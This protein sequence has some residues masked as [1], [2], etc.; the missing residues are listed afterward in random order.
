M[1]LRIVSYPSAE[2]I[3]LEEARLH[4]RV[5]ADG[6]PP[7]HPDDSLILGL[8]STAREWAE[9]F[10]GLRIAER[11]YELRMDAFADTVV[12]P[13]RPVQSVEAVTY[14]DPE[15]VEQTL[16]DAVYVFDAGPED[17]RLEDDDGAT[18][19]L[20]SDQSWPEIRGNSGDVRIRFVAGYSLPGASPQTA[21]LPSSIRAAMLLVLGH[22]YNNREDTS[23]VKLETLPL[24]ATVLLRPYR[25][26]LGMA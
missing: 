18:V 1:S 21:P 10:T 23:V 2:P 25:V 5:D 22:L 12:L 4:L 16:D 3:D 24:G 13:K 19:K 20:G 7:S 14:I 6:S 26:L 9:S 15:G 8:V 17:A 11:T